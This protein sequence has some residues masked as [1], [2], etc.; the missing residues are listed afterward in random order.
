MGR[1]VYYIYLY[2][3]GSYENGRGLMA[4]FFVKSA[5]VRRLVKYDTFASQCGP[6]HPL[7]VAH[8]STYLIGVKKH[9]AIYRGY[10]CISGAHFVVHQ[11]KNQTP[12]QHWNTS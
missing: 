4:K 11:D 1:R 8:D 2:M 7:Q 12:A 10:D 6:R 9:S 5:A 3:N